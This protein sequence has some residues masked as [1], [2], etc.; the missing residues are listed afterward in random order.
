[1]QTDT[2]SDPSTAVYREQ[3]AVNIFTL[4]ILHP[5]TEHCHKTDYFF[6]RLKR[7]FR[8]SSHPLF[9]LRSKNM[10]SPSDLH[11]Y[12]ICMINMG[13]RRVQQAATSLV[14]MS[15]VTICCKGSHNTLSSIPT[16]QIGDGISVICSSSAKYWI[17]IRL[18]FFRLKKAV[19]CNL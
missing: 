2:A 12:P 14:R 3:K 17:F 18:S 5:F 7:I 16:R 6:R 11:C 9:H 8:A 13:M 1:M 15:D 10:T 19:Y 4:F